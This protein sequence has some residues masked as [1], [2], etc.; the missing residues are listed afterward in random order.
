MSTKTERT[1]VIDE[2]EKEFRDAQGIYVTNNHKIDVATVTRLRTDVRKKGMR[3]IV[4]KNSLAR[5]AA[6]NSG[7]GVIGEYFKGPI[8]VIIAKDGAA[9]A[10]VIRDFQKDNKDLLD[11]KAAYVDGALFTNAQVQ[12]LADLP[13]REVLLSQLL[14]CLK[15]PMGN[16]AGTLSGV[17]TKFVRTLD[18]VKT[19]KEASA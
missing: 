7:K 2:L 16:L 12:A 11:V 13:S 5:I 18:A 4:V 19:K 10:K 3:F 6:K 1:A 14:G 9:P 8:A 17:L 15:A